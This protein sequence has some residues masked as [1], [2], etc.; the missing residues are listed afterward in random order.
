MVQMT[1]WARDG[2]Q[3]GFGKELFPGDLDRLSP[4]L[5]ACMEA[6]PCFATAE[7]QTVV[8]GPITYT[9]DL[10]PM[11]GPCPRLPNMWL[12]VGF[13]Y[14]IIHAGGI[15]KYLANWIANG[16]APFEL[17][18]MDPARYGP[19]MTMDYALVKTRESYG[20]NNAY[21]YPYEERRAGRPTRRVTPIHDRL[22]TAGAHMGF[23]A[24]GWETPLWYAAPGEQ[25][26]YRPSF[27][28]T[29]WQ[30]EQ[31]G[32]EYRAVTERVGLADLSNFGKFK[33]A[34]RGA[35]KLLDRAVAGT[36]PRVGRTSLVHMLTPSGRV[37]A[38]LTL[39]CT[40]ED[41]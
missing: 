9:P 7:I 10:M 8:N 36:V 22:V 1:A 37:Y 31:A 34:G 13:G 21:G 20:M 26:V 14:G 2:V 29:N 18:E 32:R 4:H 11:V 23:V 38:E 17:S 6:F 35:R 28:R 16:E 19:W 25:P 39:T 33:V 41:R 15:G 27:F 30:Y 24:G 5:E 40:E 3:P 12:A